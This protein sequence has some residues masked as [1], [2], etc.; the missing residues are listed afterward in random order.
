[1]SFSPRSLPIN[2]SVFHSVNCR[3]SQEKLTEPPLLDLL[4]SKSERI[5]EFNNNLHQNICQG[6]RKR[7]LAIDTKSAK[8]VLEGHEK[9]NQC[10]VAGTHVLDS[11]RELDVRET[12]RWDLR[13]MHTVSRMPM[14]ANIAFAGG[15]GCRIDMRN[16]ALMN[17]FGHT[18]KPIASPRAELIEGKHKTS[19]E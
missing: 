18:T 5:D 8:E 12:H 10:I 1:M 3:N 6:R 2:F 9:V 11:L 4:G 13:K 16:K 15:K 19:T 14:A 7:D 17:V